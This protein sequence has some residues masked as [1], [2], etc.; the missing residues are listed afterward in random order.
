[1]SPS[2]SARVK[3]PRMT[4]RRVITWS[5]VGVVVLGL[6]AWAAWP[7]RKSYTATSAMITVMT[8]P[9]GDVPVSLDTTYYRPRSA[10]AS[11]PAPAVLLAHGFG[12][13]KNGVVDQAEDL[14]NRGYAVM[15]WTAEGFGASGGQIH[16]DSPNWE[17][18]D[19]ERLIDWLAARPEIIKD[20]PGDPRVAAVGG[21]YGGGFSLLLAGYDK[22]VD[23][24]V[25]MITWNNLAN[26]F[27]PDADGGPASDGV[28]KKAWAGLFFGES[29][30]ATAA[31]RTP[32]QASCGRFATDVCQAYQTLASTGRAAPTAI[33]LLGRSSPSSVLDRITAPTLLIQG[34]A[35]SLFP[36]SEANANAQRPRRARRPGTRRMVH[37]RPRWRR[38]PAVGSGPDEPADCS[39]ARP[40]PEE[41]WPD[42]QRLASPTRG[43]PDW[44]PAPT[45]SWRL[46][47][48]STR[49]R[50]WVGRPP[51]TWI[52]AGPPQ[53]G[54]EPARSGNPGA[55]A[56]A[57]RWWR[58]LVVR[59]RG[60]HRA[61]R[62]ARRLLFAAAEVHYGRR[63]IA[64]GEHQGRVADRRGGAVRQALR[65]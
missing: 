45:G 40:L 38:R 41:D 50:E 43:S 21:S 23:A 52:V 12:G 62:P 46:G 16:L 60:R 14:V 27:L 20:H 54:R 39:V 11:H 51:R 61:A 53:R 17:V 26:A 8:G 49:T 4:R 58:A 10:T 24:I 37:R 47:S 32:E 31:F 1:M 13:T 33:A 30:G 57:R 3:L 5:V 22:R 19:G 44:T 28:F 25:P 64:D 18:K 65:R 59:S 42:A 6:L 9:D 63:W 55:S 48:T 7:S 34:E 35:D 15:T 36:L 2:L 56:V 29:G